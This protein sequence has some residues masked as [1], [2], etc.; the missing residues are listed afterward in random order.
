MGQSRSAE[1]HTFRSLYQTHFD[2]V[3]GLILRFG[4]GRLEAEDLTQRVFMV[5][6]RQ[7]SEPDRLRQ[8]SAWLRAVALRVVHEHFRWWR[9]RRAAT[10][11]V[12]QSWAG[13]T[14]CDVNPER[15]LLAT[16]SLQQVRG[17]L[18]RMSEKLRDALVLLDIEG[19]S[20]REAAALLGVPHN[21]MRS[22]HNHARQ[23]FKRLWDRAQERRE[24]HDE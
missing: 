2:E 20:P 12:E 5:A 3:I 19:V 14:R 11:L 13:R 7:A 17:V 9:V 10:W 15:D 21:T 24:K 6:L 23:E 18:Y 4:I 8:P 1:D 22:R 16:E